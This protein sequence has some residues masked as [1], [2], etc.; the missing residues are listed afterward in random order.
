MATTKTIQVVEVQQEPHIEYA[1]SGGKKITFGDDELMVN[2]ATRERDFPVMLDICMDKDD[3]L[4]LGTGGARNYVAQVE[5]PAREYDIAD[6]PEDE[7]GNIAEI[8][9]PVAFDISRCTL[10]LWK[11]EE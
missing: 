5:I 8:P 10:Y 7:Q 6:G 1:V 11:V 3:G 4:V 9:V 2:L